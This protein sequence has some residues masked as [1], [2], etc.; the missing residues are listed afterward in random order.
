MSGGAWIRVAKPGLLTTVQDAGRYGLQHLGV[1]PGGAMDPVALAIA[2]ALVGNRPEA[3]ALEITLIGPELEFG[4]AALVALCGAR[5]EARLDGAPLPLDRPVL[6]EQGARLAIGAARAGARACLAVAGGIAVPPVLGSR[7]TFLPAAFGGFEGRA[8]RPGDLV[9]L[10][11]DAADIARKRYGALPEKRRT[12]GGGAS[13]GWS[14]PALTLPEREPIT[15]HAME[16]RHHALFEAAS[17]RAFFEAT[18]KVLPDSNRMGFRLGG[19]ALAR[20]ASGEI[21]SEPTCLGTVQVPANGQPIALMAD[22]QTTGG[23]PR[24]AEI[25]SADVAR[26][27]QLAPGQTLRFARCTLAEA[28]ALRRAQR[29]RMRRALRALAWSYGT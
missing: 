23:Y 21:H 26:L 18:W 8:L 9:P 15:V 7:S 1:V 6:V 17:R 22:H 28:V 4:C 12:A 29:E 13:V 14:V 20:A 5:F 19:P 24:I 2:N 3:A 11:A 27:A 25:A 16:G 10:A